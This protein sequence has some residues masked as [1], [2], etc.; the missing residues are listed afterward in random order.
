MKLLFCYAD[1]TLFG[2]SPGTICRQVIMGSA[3]LTSVFGTVVQILP[4]NLW[5][6]SLKELGPKFGNGTRADTNNAVTLYNRTPSSTCP[7]AQALS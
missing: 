2:G 7:I 1:Y 3:T 5:L 4:V 6:L